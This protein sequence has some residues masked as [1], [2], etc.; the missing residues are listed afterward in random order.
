MH[1]LPPAERRG[2]SP[3]RDVGQPGGSEEEEENDAA[4]LHL[5]DAGGDEESLPQGSQPRGRRVSE[6][7]RAASRLGAWL[8]RHAAVI[9]HSCGAQI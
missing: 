7:R 9:S 6:W 5:M 2:S 3:G 1:F 4:A 8:L